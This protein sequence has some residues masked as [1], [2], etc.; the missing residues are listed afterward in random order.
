MNYSSLNSIAARNIQA[1][2]GVTRE[3]VEKLSQETSISLS[4]LK[5]RMNGEYPYTLDEIELIARH[6][7][8]DSTDLLSASFSV[9]QALADAHKEVK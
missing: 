8:L 4:T 7:N 6:W 5:R 9:T 1:M 2:R 3:S